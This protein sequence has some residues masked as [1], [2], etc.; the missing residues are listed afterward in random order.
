MS[1]SSQQLLEEANFHFSK[2]NHPKAYQLYLDAV[3]QTVEELRDSPSFKAIARGR[4]SLNRAEEILRIL[5]SQDTSSNK[6]LT[7]GVDSGTSTLTAPSN[8]S[9]SRIEIPASP[10]SK[11]LQNHQQRLHDAREKYET[12]LQKNPPEDLK[13]LRQLIQDIDVEDIYCL[14]LT[15][16]IAQVDSTAID[17]YDPS[18]FAAH[19][20]YF[21]KKLW[22]EIDPKTDVLLPN[23]EKMCKNVFR[24]LSFQ[25]YLYSSISF[26][27]CHKFAESK[28]ALAD[29]LVMWAYR[30][31]YF[32]KDI[33]TLTTLA[34]LFDAHLTALEPAL[35]PSCKQTLQ[36]LQKVWGNRSM[37]IQEELTSDMVSA[38]PV[39]DA[40]SIIVP[41]VAIFIKAGLEIFKS[42]PIGD[43]EAKFLTHYQTLLASTHHPGFN[44][45]SSGKI[46]NESLQH[47]IL[48]QTYSEDY[49]RPFWKQVLASTPIYE[50]QVELAAES[51]ISTTISPDFPTEVAPVDDSKNENND[52]VNELQ[53]RL[54]ALSKTKK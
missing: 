2:N 32:E 11:R 10:L 18:H 16:A 3:A 41:H 24:F 14:K 27:I 29:F 31:L 9:T 45:D 37:E 48:S 47:W 43:T 54:N 46:M 20:S 5:A 8:P 33:A 42:N 22:A 52:A 35:S 44:I 49:A 17:F 28:T 38:H 39:L 36:Q 7:G 53:R 50:I 21:T 15:G 1:S 25:E 19:C 34:D 13:V 23:L 12:S 40:E 6:P 30:C 26:I 4:D 51:I